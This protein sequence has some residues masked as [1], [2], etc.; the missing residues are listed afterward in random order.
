MARSSK[1]AQHSCMFRD[2]LANCST[3]ALMRVDAESRED[4]DVLSFRV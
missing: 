2:P 4:D 1:D 3:S